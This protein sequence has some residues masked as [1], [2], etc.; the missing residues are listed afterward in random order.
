VTANVF[1]RLPP[2]DSEAEA[3]VIA[4]MLVQDGWQFIPQVAAQVKSSQFFREQNG[5][6]FDAILAVWERGEEPNQITVAHE[7]AQ[8]DQID[9]IGGQGYLIQIIRELPTPYGAEFYAKIVARHA[10]YR[11]LMS[12]GNQIV[13]MALDAPENLPGVLAKARDLIDGIAASLQSS[14]LQSGAEVLDGG[15]MARLERFIADP[16]ALAGLATGWSDLD[17]IIDGWQPGFVYVI[18]G[19]TSIGK[20]TF[21]QT[22]Q[23]H[24]ARAGKRSLY[25]SSEM[26][27]AS[28]GWREIW[29]RAGLDERAIKA[30]G[31]VAEDE[32]RRLFE[33][34]NDYAVAPTMWLNPW[35]GALAEARV[36]AQQMAAKGL[37]SII[38]DHI[39]HLIERRSASRANDVADGMRA[40]KRMAIELAV[41]VLLVSHMNRSD[42]AGLLSRLLDGG[43]KERDADVVMFLRPMRH[44][45]GELRLIT[46]EQA[47]V[48]RGRGDQVI[49]ALDVFK[50]REGPSGR[51]L[52]VTAPGGRLV[53]MAR[54][55]R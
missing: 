11:Q 26:R 5:W 15:L 35:E 2:H 52:F 21:V 55:G 27:N 19:E 29:R 20:S 34:A 37:D 40:T 1:D 13:H 14:A 28:V 50:N 24:L 38:L 41:P 22:A 10:Q 30:R 45:D 4:S 25:V 12:A 42:E 47:Q 9:G 48:A 32:Q 31:A 3:A 46:N 17:L 7:L 54:D 51:V 43:A 23:Q 44:E 33:A 8:R 16:R 36:A 39:D 53:Q 6:I 18:A 49:T